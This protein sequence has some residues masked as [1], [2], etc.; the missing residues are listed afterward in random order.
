[1]EM[2]KSQSN[3]H[4]IVIPSFVHS[5]RPVVTKKNDTPPSVPE[6]ARRDLHVVKKR[7]LEEKN[8]PLIKKSMTKPTLEDNEDQLM[9]ASSSPTSDVDDKSIERID[10]GK[11]RLKSELDLIFATVQ[12]E[13]S[14]YK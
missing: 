9:S 3:I 2:N 7:V 1:M 14:I 11:R 6:M 13:F 10:I 8:S 12:Q 5:K 4:P